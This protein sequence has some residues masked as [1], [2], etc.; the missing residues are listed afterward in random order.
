M[1]L[2]DACQGAVCF[3][4]ANSRWPA[5]SALAPFAE[6]GGDDDSYTLTW[7]AD[8]FVVM[9]HA[10]K[11]RQRLDLDLL[12]KTLRYDCDGF[13]HVLVDLTGFDLLGEHWLGYDLMD[14]VLLVAHSGFTTEQDIVRCHKDIPKSRD[15]GVL[16]VG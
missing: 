2:S 12:D 1:V 4:D 13:S 11:P 10:G 15:M 5:L 9:S 16:L 8:F 6:K 7:L 14:G 3:I